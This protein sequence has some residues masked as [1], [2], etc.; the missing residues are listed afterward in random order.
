MVGVF[1]ADSTARPS[2]ATRS[3]DQRA[4]V[5]G[6]QAG[7][8]WPTTTLVDPGCDLI[9]VEPDE[10]A[11]LDVGNAALGD[12][13]PDVAWCHAEMVGEAGDVHEGG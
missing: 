4:T 3:Y 9:R 5:S 2:R 1:E 8:A 11:P 10:V 12:E 13:S 7:S 6:P